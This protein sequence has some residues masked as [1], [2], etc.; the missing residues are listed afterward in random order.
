MFSTVFSALAYNGISWNGDSN[1]PSE[2]DSSKLKTKHNQIIITIE[3]PTYQSTIYS[4]A[5]AA[6]QSDEYE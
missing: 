3:R 1:F 4:P 6:A 5:S 2:D